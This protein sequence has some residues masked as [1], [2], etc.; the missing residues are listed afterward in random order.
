MKFIIFIWQNVSVWNEVVLFA[1]KFFL[2]FNEVEA[3]PI[4]PRDLITHRKMIYP[5]KFIQS[6]IQ[7]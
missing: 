3:E 7:K 5:L 2:S 6:F 1:P 4:L